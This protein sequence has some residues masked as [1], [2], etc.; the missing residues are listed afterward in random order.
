MLT[1]SSQAEM[2]PVAEHRWQSWLFPGGA[3]V[4]VGTGYCGFHSNAATLI[5]DL[6]HQAAAEQ[7]CSS[8]RL[9]LLKATHRC[10]MEEEG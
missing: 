4:W 8:V 10:A 9:Q 3:W 1:G 5:S 2:T 7:L 6:P